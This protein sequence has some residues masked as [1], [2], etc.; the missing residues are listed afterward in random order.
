MAMLNNQRVNIKHMRIKPELWDLR[1]SSSNVPSLWLEGFNKLNGQGIPKMGDPP[2]SIWKSTK[3]RSISWTRTCSTIFVGMSNLLSP[4]RVASQAPKLPSSTRIR[5]RLLGTWGLGD[6][7][8]KPPIP[9][10]V[11]FLVEGPGFCWFPSHLCWLNVQFWL[12][13]LFNWF[14]FVLWTIIFCLLKFT[15]LGWWP[16]MTSD[17]RG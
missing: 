11:L 14:P 3:Q 17:Q 10:Q 12:F 8:W 16:V 15:F 13:M 6:L 1:I 9:V 5:R 2:K 7:A 4:D